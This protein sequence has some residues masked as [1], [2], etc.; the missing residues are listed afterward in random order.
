MKCASSPFWMRVISSC[1]ADSF[2]CIIVLSSLCILIHLC[3]HQNRLRHLPHTCAPWRPKAPRAQRCHL[4]QARAPRCKPDQ[5]CAQPAVSCWGTWT[6]SL[7]P[8]Y[9]Q[10]YA[11]LWSDVVVLCNITKLWILVFG[12]SLFDELN[13]ITVQKGFL[14]VEVTATSEC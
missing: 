14:T 1:S 11:F 10:M 4:W 6:P 9:I 3:F 13:W 5:V 12:A 8:H 7:S 2:L